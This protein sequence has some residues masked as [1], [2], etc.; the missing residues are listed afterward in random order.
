MEEILL[1]ESCLFLTP[2]DPKN[3]VPVGVCWGEQ[4]FNDGP[5]VFI[6]YDQS[7]ALVYCVHQYL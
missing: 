2:I 6:F 3:M 4:Y 7:Q 1:N 5:A